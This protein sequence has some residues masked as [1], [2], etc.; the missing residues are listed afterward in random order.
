MRS[1]ETSGRPDACVTSTARG[2]LVSF[3]L[4][5]AQPSQSIFY[6]PHE[7]DCPS[8]LVLHEDGV[9]AWQLSTSKNFRVWNLVLPLDVQETTEADGV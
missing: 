2:V 8:K 4:S 6:N 9:D 7:V 3:F 1:P 5:G